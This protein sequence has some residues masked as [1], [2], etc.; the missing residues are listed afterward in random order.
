MLAGLGGCASPSRGPFRFLVVNDLHHASAD[1][2]PFFAR[3]VE[4]MRRHTDAQFCLIVGDLTDKGRPESLRAIR[5]TFAR[6]AM[7]VHCVP[8]NHDCDQEENTRL[9]ADVFPGKLNYRFDH[10]GWQFLGLDSTDGNKWGG[11][12][13]Q[14][15]TLTWLDQNLPALDRYRP[16][17]L[18]THFPLVPEVNPRL[19]PLNA[20]ELVTRFDGWNLRCAFSGHYHARTE[21]PHAAATLLTN[22]CCSRAR[23]NHDRSVPEGYLLCT[24]HPDGRLERELVR[25]TSAELS[26]SSDPA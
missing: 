12:L 16:T 7:P 8:G 23:D 26:R 2:D 25:F 9:Y 19:V 11:S 1:C 24:A 6:L 4:D 3:L 21:R 5:E 15:A 17:V 22:C 20:P 14:P 18:F 10:G 13:I